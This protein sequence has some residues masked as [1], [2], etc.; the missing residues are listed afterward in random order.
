MRYGFLAV[1]VTL[2][3]ISGCTDILLTPGSD[4][5]SVNEVA[6]EEG[7]PDVLVIRDVLLEAGP[8]GT[9]VLPDQPVT[10]SFVIENV[11]YEKYARNVEVELFNAANFRRGTKDENGNYPAC[12]SVG[13][14]PNECTGPAQEEGV[15]M[16][17]L[18][19]LGE[20]DEGIPID[21]LTGFVT[22]ESPQG[23][24]SNYEGACSVGDIPPGGVKT[25]SFDLRTPEK[26]SIGNVQ[27]KTELNF[28]V[29]YE[30]YSTMSYEF[31]VV[32]P[33][34]IENLRRAGQTVT[35]DTGKFF[36][37]G[38]I[39]IDAE[40]KGYEYALAGLPITVIVTLEDKGTK[41]SLISSQIGSG[42]L[43]VKF[44]KDFVKSWENTD[45]EYFNDCP[46]EN[47]MYV[48][49]N[50]DKAIDLYKK[51]S[52]PLQ[53]RIAETPSPDEVAPYK[54]YFIKSRADYTYELRD[55]VKVTISPWK[56]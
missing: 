28:R 20:E 12:G 51:K 16:D 19:G 17:Q 46:E 1:I 5:F 39:K 47:G 24:P 52:N 8:S 34:E 44:P 14:L 22:G 40:L 38:P 11:D 27:V 29:S 15:A 41:G 13:C 32:D 30:F 23:E 18:P 6:E 35:F 9:S 55:S 10:L 7:S 56:A 48:C 36:S 21:P 25:I 33:G 4:V 3:F 43:E 49:T 42:D 2:T 37:S 54:S 26:E 45:N 53:F 50:T 31:K